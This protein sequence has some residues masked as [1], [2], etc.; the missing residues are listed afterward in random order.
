M[1]HSPSTNAR[2]CQEVW[3]D[4]VSSSLLVPTTR[5]ITTELRM[6][7]K[8]QYFIEEHFQLNHAESSSAA[9]LENPTSKNFIY[10]AMSLSKCPDHHHKG[11]CHVQC[12]RQQC[13]TN[14][15]LLIGPTVHSTLLDVLIHFHFYRVTMT[16]DV[17]KM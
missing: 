15:Q 16:T 7:P 3:A 17:S 1:I 12:N 9:D 5:Y 13:V 10:Q 6:I 2:R 14:N 8:I 4:L 11:L